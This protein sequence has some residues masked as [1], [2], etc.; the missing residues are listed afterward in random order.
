MFTSRT[1]FSTPENLFETVYMNKEGTW[2]QI[3]RVCVRTDVRVCVYTY[4]CTYVCA[5]GDGLYG[6]TLRSSWGIE[7]CVQKER[8]I[9]VVWWII[10]KKKEL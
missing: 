8:R 10:M 1:L 9:R 4:V 7:F 5:C 3:Q 6:W 2:K